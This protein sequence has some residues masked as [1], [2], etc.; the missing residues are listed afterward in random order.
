MPKQDMARAETS[1]LTD[2]HWDHQFASR[3]VFRFGSKISSLQLKNIEKTD[4]V[5]KTVAGQ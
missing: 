5:V 2:L 4:E 1:L 3:R